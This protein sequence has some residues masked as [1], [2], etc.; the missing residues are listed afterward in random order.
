M[1]VFQALGPARRGRGDLAPGRTGM[2]F[3]NADDRVLLVRA[4][5]AVDGPQ[6]CANNHYFH[7]PELEAVLRD[8]VARY[9]NVRVLAGHEAT[10]I[11]QDADGVTLRSTTSPAT[12]PATVRARWLVGCDG[13]RSTVRRAIGATDGGP[14]AAPALAGVRRDGSSATSAARPHGAALR[15]G[16]ADDYMCCVTG[17]GAA[18]RSC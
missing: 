16:P 4:G 10:A 6:G 13:G 5:S 8:G 14:R 7:Q 1:R 11:A 18:G 15:P 2:H 3:V 9:P 17:A 12:T